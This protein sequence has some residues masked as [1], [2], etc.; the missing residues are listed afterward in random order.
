[1]ITNKLTE[2]K[3]RKT[4]LID[5]QSERMLGDGGGLSVRITRSLNNVNK[6]NCYWIFR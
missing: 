3:I 1:M 6:D 4:K 2:A 5:G